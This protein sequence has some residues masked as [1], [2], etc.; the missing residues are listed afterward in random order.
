MIE[1]STCQPIADFFFLTDRSLLGFSGLL[2][3]HFHIHARSHS[4]ACPLVLCFFL[5]WGSSLSFC[6]L[7]LLF[8]FA[9]CPAPALLLSPPHPGFFCW[10]GRC[11]CGLVVANGTEVALIAFV[12]CWYH[13]TLLP[14]GAFGDHFPPPAWSLTP[15]LLLLSSLLPVFSSLCFSRCCTDW[16][17]PTHITWTFKLLRNTEEH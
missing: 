13:L 4:S 10:P 12:A 9:P 2:W 1:L 5:W 14:L 17:T 11:V 3:V 7:F 16:H 6:F 8:S 15:P